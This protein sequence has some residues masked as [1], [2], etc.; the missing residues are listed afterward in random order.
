MSLMLSFARDT[1]K[2]N[3]LKICEL[4]NDYCTTSAGR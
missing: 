4:L 2:S 1:L 3:L